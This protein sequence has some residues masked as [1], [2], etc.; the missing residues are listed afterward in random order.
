[1]GGNIFRYTSLSVLYL[2]SWC[3]LKQIYL[4][5]IDF[6]KITFCHRN[7]FIQGNNFIIHNMTTEYSNKGVETKLRVKK[8]IMVYKV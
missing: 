8:I 5:L 1:M 6:Q 4:V 2:D 3:V 7:N